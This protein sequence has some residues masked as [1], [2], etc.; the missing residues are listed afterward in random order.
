MYILY[1]WYMHSNVAS[2][3]NAFMLELRRELG[4]KFE[5]FQSLDSFAKSSWK[6]ILEF[7]QRRCAWCMGRKES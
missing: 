2:I 5:H 6:N 4:D 1:I 7:N 3:G